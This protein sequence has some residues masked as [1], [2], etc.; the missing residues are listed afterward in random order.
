MAPNGRLAVGYYDIRIRGP[1]LDYAMS[2]F[3]ASTGA[4]TGYTLVSE[5]S[6]PVWQLDPNFDTALNPC[7]GIARNTLAAPGPFFVAWGDGR[8]P[9]R[10]ATSASTRTFSSQECRRAD[11]P[12]PPAGCGSLRPSDDPAERLHTGDDLHRTDRVSLRAAHVARPHR[13]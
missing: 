7:A 10:R 1:L 2:F 12:L 6:F 5:Q 11:A 4:R 3:R 8:D 13:S 9:G